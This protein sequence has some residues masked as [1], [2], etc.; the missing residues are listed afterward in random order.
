MVANVGL[1]RW[2]IPKANEQKIYNFFQTLCVLNRL[3]ADAYNPI[4]FVGHK[5]VLIP[6]TVVASFAVL[7]QYKWVQSAPTIIYT[8]IVAGMAGCMY[9]Q[10]VWYQ[11]CMSFNTSAVVLHRRYICFNWTKGR[12]YSWK[13][14]CRG[15]PGRAGGPFNVFRQTKPHAF[16]HKIFV[17]TMKIHFYVRK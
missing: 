16:F 4:S 14:L 2:S 1:C 8:A 5:F 6:L 10:S 7:Y 13:K 9:F 12:P 11:I 3:L 17:Y 15:L